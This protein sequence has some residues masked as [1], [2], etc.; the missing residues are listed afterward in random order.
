MS[1]DKMYPPW[2]QGFC[3]QLNALQVSGKVR[4]YT[5]GKDSTHP[6]LCATQNGWICKACGYKQDWCHAIPYPPAVAAPMPPGTPTR[7]AVPIQGWSEYKDAWPSRERMAKA[8]KLLD[9]V[10]AIMGENKVTAENK[11]PETESKE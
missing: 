8:L 9:A 3:D 10:E 4:P 1:D 7:P 5:C 6:V 11:Q 2:R